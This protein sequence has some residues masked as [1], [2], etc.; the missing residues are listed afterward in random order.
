M[1]TEPNDPI[2]ASREVINFEV[3][4]SSF[5]HSEATYH[6]GLTKREYLAGKNMQ[7]LL[8]GITGNTSAAETTIKEAAKNN[9]NIANYIASQA[10]IYADALIT[11]LS[12]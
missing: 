9:E 1:K 5:E 4:G 8:S 2:N 11:E 7:G 10:V 12:K 3:P 6:T